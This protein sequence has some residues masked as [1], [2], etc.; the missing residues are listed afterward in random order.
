MNR[1]AVYLTFAF[2]ILAAVAG[3]AAPAPH[4]PRHLTPCKIAGD[5]G[6]AEALCGTYQ[7]WEN[8]AAKSGRKIG[9][10]IVVLPAQT[11]HPKPD[12]IFFLAGGPGQAATTVAGGAAGNPV[13]RDRDF[14]YVDQRGTG[15]PNRL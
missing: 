3:A 7:V 2:L 4:P 12:P 15:E 9:L 8:R 13:R 11:L 14:V 10:K 5:G 1:R 6:E